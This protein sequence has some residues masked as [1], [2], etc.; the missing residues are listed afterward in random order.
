MNIYV[1][2]VVM[3]LKC[4]FLEMMNRHVHHVGQIIQQKRCHHSDFLRV[5]SIHHHLQV[6]DRPVQLAVP[7][8]VQVAMDR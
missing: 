3:N 6:Q 5:L 8:T 4:L 7:Q 2:S 1:K